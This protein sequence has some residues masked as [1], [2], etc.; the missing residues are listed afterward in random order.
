ML[1]ITAVLPVY[2]AVSV[3]DFQR[4]IQSL[5]DQEEQA[6]EVIVVVDGPVPD[7]LSAAIDEAGTRARVRVLRLPVNQGGA[8]ASKAAFD[9]ATQPWIARQDAD[10]VSM[11]ERFRLLWELAQSGD[12]AAVG[13]AML[14]FDDN[15]PENVVRVRRLPES[16]A[17]LARYV[18]LNT[19]INHP[20][21]LMRADAVAAVGGMHRVHFMEDYDLWARLVSA[22]YRLANTSVPVVR[23]NAG[24]GMFDRR[25]GPEMAKAEREMQANLVHYGLISWPRAGAN[26]ILRQGFRTLPRP[27]L[28]RTYRWLFH[29][30]DAEVRASVNHKESSNART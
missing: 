29:R 25:T 14:E 12:F 4:S 8:A 15:D 2:H 27:F 21:V 20:T 3:G 23:F 17:A 6:A 26:Y 16:P 10:D 18:K 24:S 7:D 11:P 19:P 9:I 13:G 5:H 30:A 22:G 1:P 28:T